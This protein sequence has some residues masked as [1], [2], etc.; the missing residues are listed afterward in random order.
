M[1]VC[2]RWWAGVCARLCG[3]GECE[4][5]GIGLVVGYVCGCV[6]FDVGVSVGKG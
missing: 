2:G 5:G 1:W 6:G 3:R 4:C